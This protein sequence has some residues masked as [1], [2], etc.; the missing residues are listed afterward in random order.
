MRERWIVLG[1]GTSALGFQ[2]S[3]KTNVSEAVLMGF[4]ST[5]G[6]VEAVGSLLRLLISHVFCNASPWDKHLCSCDTALGVKAIKKKMMVSTRCAF[7]LS[8]YQHWAVCALPQQNTWER[9]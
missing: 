5:P 1:L 3:I 6:Q 8:F 2:V 4:N 9:L 7:H